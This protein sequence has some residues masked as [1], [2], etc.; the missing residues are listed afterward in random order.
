MCVHEAFGLVFVIGV[1]VPTTSLE[2]DEQG[3]YLGYL[4][5][6]FSLQLLEITGFKFENPTPEYIWEKVH[7]T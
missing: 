6:V 5:S 1:Q 3:R 7:L 2:G 4:V